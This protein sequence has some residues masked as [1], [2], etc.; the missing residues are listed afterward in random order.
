METMYKAIPFSPVAS[1]TDDIG[2][3]D[4][5]IPVSDVDAFPDAPNLAVIGG[6]DTQSE[7]ILYTAKSGSALSGC[8]RGVEGTA[9]AWSTGEIISRNFTAKDHDVFIANIQELFTKV[10]KSAEIN[11]SGHLI[12]TLQDDS[13]FDAGYA[14]GDKGDKGNTGATGETGPAGADGKDGAAA[15]IQVGTVTTGEPGTQAQVTNAGTTSAAKFNFVIPRG[16]DGT[17]GADGADG[18]QGPAGADGGYYLPTVDASGNLTWQASNPEMPSVEAR[19]IK[20]EPGKD[21]EDATPSQSGTYTL[22]TGGWALSGSRYIQTISV[23]IVL[24]D[25]PVILV[26]CALTGL[27]IDADNQVLDAWNNGPATCNAVASPGQI[28]FYSMTQPTINIPV[29]IGVM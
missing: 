5:I 1:L 10:I 23:P 7:T 6:V 18:A 25:T 16:E 11:G 15:T 9:K 14:K 19:N 8:T 26:D 22:T 4:T 17:D 3:G 21:G 12:L 13:T 2:D 20:G 28:S 27:D 29:N 24:S